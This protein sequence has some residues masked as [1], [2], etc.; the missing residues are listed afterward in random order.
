M[1]FRKKIQAARS[2]REKFGE[3]NAA[4]VPVGWRTMATEQHDVEIEIEIDMDAIAKDLGAAA[5]AN[6]GRISRDGH[7]VVRVVGSKK[8]GESKVQ[9]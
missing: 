6:K 3:G 9:R 2:V 1:K 8:I 5:F 7:V 4:G